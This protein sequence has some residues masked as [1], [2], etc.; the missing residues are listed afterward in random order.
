MSQLRSVPPETTD[1]LLMK[2]QL[3]AVA[4][5]ITLGRWGAGA[6]GLYQTVGNYNVLTF[7]GINRW[8]GGQVGA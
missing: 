4:Q 6:L 3:C 8:A 5:L 7:W 2:V 1:W